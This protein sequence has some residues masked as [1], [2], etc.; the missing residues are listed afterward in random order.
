[1]ICREVGGC[2]QRCMGVDAIN[3][4]YTVSYEADKENNGGTQ[5]HENFKNW[6]M[7]F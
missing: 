6:L 3:A 4:I 2:I 5:Y 7:R 1:M